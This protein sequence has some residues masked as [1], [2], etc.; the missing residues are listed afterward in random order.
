MPAEINWA[1]MD[2][3]IFDLDGTLWDSAEG[4]AAAW[5]RALETL[6]P[7]L[8]PPITDT[9]MRGC[10]GLPMD[11]LAQRLFPMAEPA[12]RDQLARACIEEEHRWLSQQGGRIYPGVAE[13]LPQLAQSHRLAIASNCEQGY[14]ENFLRLSGFGRYF[15]DHISFGDTNQPKGDNIRLL[16]RRNRFRSAC[17]VGDTVMDWQAALSAGLPFVFARY[18]FGQAP[19]WDGVIDR[20]DRLPAL[21]SR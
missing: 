21:L 17:F 9:E 5:Q 10:M 12:C 7:G 8:R 20:F 13:T 14:I 2:A 16:I 11:Q 4:V 3:V 18:G 15:C 19:G 1:G 6:A